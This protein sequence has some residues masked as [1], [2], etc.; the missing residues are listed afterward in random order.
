MIK[1]SYE[2]E[3]EF[4]AILS[5]LDPIIKDWKKTNEKKGKF[6]RVYIKTQALHSISK[7]KQYKYT[8]SNMLYEL[9]DTDLRF[10]SQIHTALKQ[11]K[12]KREDLSY[13]K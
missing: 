7:A 3:S 13:V 4:K 6:E 8:I 2:T 1:V 11:H 10:L 9:P 12:E 5:L